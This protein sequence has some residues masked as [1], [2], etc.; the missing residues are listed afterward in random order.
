M[1]GIFHKM[2]KVALFFANF[3][4]LVI[5]YTTF[6]YLFEP[7]SIAQ[8]SPTYTIFS[9]LAFSFSTALI[10]L[11]LTYLWDWIKSRKNKQS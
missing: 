8:Q 6:L 1:M 9:I 5:V 4:C 11:V 2:N 7:E 10:G 3:V